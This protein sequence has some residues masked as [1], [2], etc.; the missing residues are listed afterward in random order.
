VLLASATDT[1]LVESIGRGRAG[2]SMDGFLTSSTVRPA[3]APS[4]IEAIVAYLRSWEKQ[5]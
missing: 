4:E 1:Y 5:P 2:T 3:L